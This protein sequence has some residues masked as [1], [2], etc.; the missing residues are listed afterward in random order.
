MMVGKDGDLAEEWLELDNGCM[1]CELKQIALS[2]RLIIN[3]TDLVSVA[4]VEELEVLIRSVNAF[5]PT[6]RSVKAEIPI[7]FML[8]LHAF[9]DEV[10]LNP[11]KQKSGGKTDCRSIGC[12][13]A[14]HSHPA[15]IS[16]PNNH[17]ILNSVST[18]LVKIPGPVDLDKVDRWLQSVLWDHTLPPPRITSDS[19]GGAEQDTRRVSDNDK[20]LDIIRLKAL[21]LTVDDNVVIVQGVQEIYDKQTATREQKS[22][23]PGDQDQAIEGKLI[24][25][26]H[27]L[28]K[29]AI[30]KSFLRNCM[31]N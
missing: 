4:D 1:C 10:G 11:F 6:L 2:D 19:A 26:G 28:D 8:D 7:E 20:A 27:Y 29:N 30:E 9:D 22:V 13:E 18:V 5:A 15:P 21:L 25:I 12:N 3:K 16:V 31:V 17:K 14:G 24:L 23:Q